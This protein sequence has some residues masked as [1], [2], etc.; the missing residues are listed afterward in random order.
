MAFSKAPTSL[1][2]DVLVRN[3]DLVTPRLWPKL[4]N[5]ALALLRIVAGLMFMQHGLQKYFGVQLPPGMP[6]MPTFKPFTQL[7]IASVLEI[8]G[9]VLIAAGLFTRVTAFVLSGEM[10]VAYFQAHAPRGWS[11]LVNQGE[12]AVLYCFVFLFFASVGGGRYS[13]DHLFVHR[14]ASRAAPHDVEETSLASEESV[15]R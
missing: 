11:P 8:V 12:L 15:K 3:G 9:G 4:P 6:S 1:R 13:L 5:I 14:R 2:S 10:A 7:W